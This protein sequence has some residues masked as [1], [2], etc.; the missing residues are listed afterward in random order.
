MAHY[1]IVLL[2]YLVGHSNHNSTALPWY[3]YYDSKTLNIVGESLQAIILPSS[4]KTGTGSENEC[5]PA[6]FATK[7]AS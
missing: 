6:V 2:T 1:N 3:Y 4:S 5:P 7:S